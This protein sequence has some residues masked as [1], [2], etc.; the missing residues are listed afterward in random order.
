MLL[1]GRIPEDGVTSQD[2][3]YHPHAETEKQNEHRVH[4]DHSKDTHSLLS[5]ICLSPAVFHSKSIY[6]K[7]R[8]PG[9]HYIS[10]PFGIV[11]AT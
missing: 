9:I 8:Y 1:Q 5:K 7:P 4:T 2:R 6:L 3:T 11:T 10:F